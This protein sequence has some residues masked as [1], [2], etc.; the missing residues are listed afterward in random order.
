MDAAHLL[1]FA[2]S[3]LCREK[4]CAFTSTLSPFLL[5]LGRVRWGLLGITNPSVRG[6]SY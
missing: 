4:S 1:S 3:L 5:R 6:Y 2:S